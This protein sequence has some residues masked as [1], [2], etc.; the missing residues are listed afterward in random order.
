MR[1]LKL[2]FLAA[3]T[4]VFVSGCSS[5][6]SLPPPVYKSSSALFQITQ[7]D[8]K[9]SSVEFTE[10]GNYVVLRNGSRM[11]APQGNGTSRA[12]AKTETAWLFFSPW[13]QPLVR[14]T[15]YNNIITGKYT[16]TDDTT[17]VLEGFGT[18][19][20]NSQNG[21][22]YSLVITET[23]SS[24]YTLTAAKKE[25]FK[26]SEPTD[27]LCRTWRISGMHLQMSV[28]ASE[29]GQSFSID[30]DE[31]VDN[32]N[33]AELMYKVYETTVKKIIRESGQS[34]SESQLK[35]ALADQ[36]K[37]FEKTYPYVEN[38][39]FTQ[40]GTYMVTYK[41]GRLAVATWA[42]T[43]DGFGKIR[44]SWDYDNMS[45]ELSNDCS[46][47]FSGKRCYLVEER[48]DLSRIGGEFRFSSR[49]NKMTYTL[50]EE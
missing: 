40:A 14:S 33:T 19:K 32:G 38:M 37:E 47:E 20:V 49:K 22:N 46:V 7:T 27:K 25:Q 11:S 30:I 5:E 1:R 18:I 2:F 12:D 4:A 43:G 10:S 41:D 21:T 48:A 35:M 24:P 36:K 16:K 34:V 31:K 28:S 13:N 8:S 17:Y 44:Y 42:W 50:E 9:L 15:A 6:G 39:I 3:I 26:D 29:D 23:G 45:S